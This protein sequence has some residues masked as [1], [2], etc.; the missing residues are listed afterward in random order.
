MNPHCRGISLLLESNCQSKRGRKGEMRSRL[1][2]VGRRNI[3]QRIYDQESACWLT[4]TAA[5][6]FSQ[7]TM[8]DS[9]KTNVRRH[10]ESPRFFR[11]A[12]DL[13]G[14]T[15]SLRLDW[16][17]S[18]THALRANSTKPISRLNLATTIPWVYHAFGP[19][20]G[21]LRLGFGDNFAVVGAS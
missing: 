7:S 9:F 18:R 15:P 19:R 20:H 4:S 3:P 11:G 1:F 13:Q 12:R 6:V 21:D 14:T 17:R 5:V 2:S 10:P 16:N 8:R